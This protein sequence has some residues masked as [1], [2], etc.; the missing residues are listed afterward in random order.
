LA[1]RTG[2]P[3]YVALVRR[4][5]DIAMPMHDEM[6]DAVFMGCP[7]LAAAGK[8]TGEARYF[9]MALAHLRN[10]ERL[11]LRPDGLYRHSPLNDAAWGRGNAFPALGMAL[12]LSRIPAAHPAFPDLLAAFRRLLAVLARYQDEDGMWRQAIDNP[13]AWPEF[14]ATAMIGAAMRRGVRRGWLEAREYQPRIDRAWQAVSA[15]TSPEG[16]L[17]DVCESTGKQKLAS[18]Y[19]RRAAILDRDPRGGAMALLFA[20]EMAALE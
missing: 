11:C 20:V 2:D 1:E 19:L 6:S 10:L 14:S 3:A 13:G 15:R 7:I 4:A 5:A 17:T 8:L 18:D 12:A 16:V 9:D